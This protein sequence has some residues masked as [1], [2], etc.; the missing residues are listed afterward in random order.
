MCTVP[1]A[2]PIKLPEHMI[3]FYDSDSSAA[4]AAKVTPMSGRVRPSPGHYGQLE[5][6]CA[7]TTRQH[8]SPRTTTKRPRWANTQVRGPCR[9]VAGAGFEPA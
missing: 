4:P 7:E 6:S 1:K 3:A 9:L 8:W 2:L 5:G